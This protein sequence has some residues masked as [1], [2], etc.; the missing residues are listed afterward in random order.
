[1]SYDI[2]AKVLIE[3]CRG[4]ILQRQFYRGWCPMSC[5]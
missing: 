1:M 3:K 2:A 5:R 4:E